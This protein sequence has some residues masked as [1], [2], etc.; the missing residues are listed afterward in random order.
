MKLPVLCAVFVLLVSGATHADTFQWTFPVSGT[1]NNP[2]NWTDVTPPA[3]LGTP[4]VGDVAVHNVGGT[5]NVVFT[6]NENSDE[7]FVQAGDVT[8]VSNSATARQYQISTD[9]DDP[10]IDID[11]SGGDLQIGMAGN[12]V[13]VIGL[14]AILSVGTSNTGDGTLSIVGSSS[15]LS[16]V[17]TSRTHNVGG[18]GNTGKLNVNNN[19]VADISGT[20]DIGV[21]TFNTTQ[22]SLDIE[23]AGRL[24]TGN[25]NIAT[26]D[27]SA[28]G[29][30]T[31]TGSASEINLSGDLEIGSKSGGS[32]RLD[33]ASNGTLDVDGTTTINITGTL[34][35]TG[36]KFVSDS[37]V[38]L[39]GGTFTKGF[40]ATFDLAEDQ[41][42]QASEGAQVDFSG[43]YFLNDNT[44]F[45]FN[46]G[47]DFTANSSLFIG[48]ST[49]GTVT[50]S[51]QGSTFSAVA[52]TVGT[53]GATGQLTV[54]NRAT[55]T[56]GGNVNIAT[57]SSGST[58]GTILVDGVDST[59]TQTGA[60]TLTI[61]ST[62]GTGSATLE[63]ENN[64]TYTTGTGLTTINAT[65]SVDIGSGNFLVNGDIN[66]TGG[67]LTAGLFG[68][69]TLAD[70]KTLTASAGGL[71]TTGQGLFVNRSTAYDINTGAD[72]LVSTSLLIGN[73]SPGQVE[74]DG[75][76]STLSADRSI[77]GSG[78]TGQLDLSNQA[79]G[80]FPSGTTLIGATNGV[81]TVRVESGADMTTADVE[82]AAAP[83]SQGMLTI[84]GAGSTFTQQG[85]STL[86]VGTNSSGLAAIV[87]ISDDGA[88]TT[89]TGT[90]TIHEN[91]LID[92]DDGDFSVLGDMDVDG[93]I[94]RGL[95]SSG[96]GGLQW[97]A[98]K[99]LTIQNGGSVS[100]AARYDTPSGSSIVVTGA[101]SQ[102]TPLG[103]GGLL[104]LN[105]ASQVQVLDGGLFS[106]R[107]RVADGSTIDV[108]ADSRLGEFS[109]AEGTV[110]I[111]GG[112]VSGEGIALGQATGSGN[113][114]LQAT[115]G[116]T[117]DFDDALSTESL[118]LGF[119][120][121]GA[122]AV[123]NI[124]GANSTLDL[125]TSVIG[126]PTGSS[127]ELDI[128]GG[129]VTATDTMT[130]NS[131]GTV[132]LSGGAL[133]ATTIDHAHGGQFNFAGGTL[134]VESF[135]G[136]LVNQGGT[137]APGASAGGT[138]IVGDY[139]QQNGA[140][141]AIEIG[142]T[143]AVT[144]YDFVSVS[145]NV[146]LDGLLELS[147]LDSFTPSQL[148]TFTVL[149]AG[150]LAGFFDNATPGARLDTVG[151]EGSFLVDI[152][153]GTDQIV[154]RDFLANTV[155]ADLNGDGFV[156]GLD[157]GIL[158]GN[159]DQTTDPAGGELNGTAPVDGLDLGILLGAWNP[160]ALSATRAVPEPGALALLA[161]GIV[162]CVGGGRLK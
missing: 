65:G 104:R 75:A 154:L 143:A 13:Q 99:S 67:S 19:G 2:A 147:L 96:G 16:A 58:V 157:L 62:T 121:N 141:L 108:D 9:G 74:V 40:G 70:G 30:A 38:V 55:G 46:S 128:T 113:A 127:G 84:A 101:G 94:L 21:S 60:S 51:G 107:V 32:G 118:R 20:L 49:D 98:N 115:A 72:L 110:N 45:T 146:L 135:H 81:G 79:T 95:E 105:G 8:F 11:I 54:R 44:T 148:D 80:T 43:I 76:G 14:D 109:I 23:S 138:T 132:N 41:A 156:D 3:T 130:L 125:E 114:V 6:Q 162:V 123:L 151:G 12:P 159:F 24:L 73:G 26:L 28:T 83:N 106:N 64:A 120:V 53:A 31:V 152:D 61:G 137:L 4:G 78:D 68:N 36:G 111:T 66:V 92:L 145:G 139:T 140:T 155:P 124:S 103:L 1:Y 34:N 97:A 39:A 37:D 134:S 150:S 52:T 86:T 93:G 35:M 42:L 144:E 15:V 5:Y 122:N 91:G 7:F 100:I 129:L 149:T 88:F 117:L 158:L 142:G 102:L 153:F 50:V 82:V 48:Q 160:P 57:N 71:V 161:L 33:I 29:T 90:T 131:T 56:I 47:A 27:T 18:R 69:S 63:I 10:D 133:H 17:G 77:I 126:S 136:N 87:T 59:I 112:T 25:L 116:A 89:G 85:A 22:G 119:F